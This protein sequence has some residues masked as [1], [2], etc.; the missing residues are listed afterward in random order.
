MTFPLRFYDTAQVP[1]VSCVSWSSP[2]EALHCAG[3][4]CISPMAPAPNPG[5]SAAAV[6][7]GIASIGIWRLLAVA[8]PHLGALI[9]MLQTETDF[10]SRVG[11]LLAW[12]ILNFFFIAL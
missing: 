2:A 4:C 8:A 3:S 10:G 1:A 9:L 12:G 6:A 11:F 7:A 5:S